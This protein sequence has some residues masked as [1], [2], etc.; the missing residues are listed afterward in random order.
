MSRPPKFYIVRLRADD[1]VVCCGSKK[2]CAKRMRISE[3]TFL[4]YVTKSRKGVLKKYEIDV[5]LGDLS[6]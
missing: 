6:V 2:E 3:L 4:S 5:E 1:Q